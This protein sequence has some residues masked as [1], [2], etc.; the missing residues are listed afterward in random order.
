MTLAPSLTNYFKFLIC[1]SHSFKTS[2]ICPVILA[3]F[4]PLGLLRHLVA[5][6]SVLASPASGSTYFMKRINCSKTAT[7]AASSARIPKLLAY[8]M[9]WR[10]VSL[11]V[12][13]RVINISRRDGLDLCWKYF[14]SLTPRFSRRSRREI[15]SSFAISPFAKQKIAVKVFSSKLSFTSFFSFTCFWNVEIRCIISSFMASLCWV[16]VR[17]SWTAIRSTH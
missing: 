11:M 1:R 4:A 8:L 15:N 5:R 9:H 10:H 7:S 14:N 3:A 13:P 12:S 16:V 2:R 17:W 6:N